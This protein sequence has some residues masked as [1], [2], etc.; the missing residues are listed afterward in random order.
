MSNV[1]IEPTIL[2]IAGLPLP[3]HLQG[4]DFLDASAARRTP[5][6]AGRDRMDSTH[7]AMRAVRSQDFKYILNLMPERPYCQFNDY[8][9]RSYPG[10]HC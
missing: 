4:H 9:E 2:R 7:D 10:W 1:D 8:K 6:L 5:D 3:E